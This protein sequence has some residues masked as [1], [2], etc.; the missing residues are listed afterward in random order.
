MTKS[1]GQIE[2]IFCTS[3]IAFNVR[4]PFIQISKKKFA[5][6]DIEKSK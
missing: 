5:Q 3:I 1:G 4:L 2:S 6:F